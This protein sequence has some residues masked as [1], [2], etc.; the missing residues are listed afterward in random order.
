[1]ITIDNKSCKRILYKI[2][3]ECLMGNQTHGYDVNVIRKIA[4]DIAFARSLDLE[5]CLVVGG[6]NIYRGAYGEK[7]GMDRSVA[8]YM[9]MMAT[10]MNAI[11][12]QNI[13]EQENVPARVQSAIPVTAICEPYIRRRAVRHLEKGRVV[14]FAAGTGNPFFTTDT[15]AT[16]RS[17]EMDCDLMLKGTSVDGIYSADPKIEKSAVRFDKISYQDL[18]EK[19]LKVMD[20]TAVSMAKDRKMPIIVFSI[21]QEN[22]LQRVLSNNSKYTIIE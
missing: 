12:L 16:L 21:K 11:A 7:M 5:V 1:M 20:I 4:N 15:T 9:G 22:A 13:L 10:I 3:G 6:G 17:L 19:N 8:D 18:I 2:S 14:I